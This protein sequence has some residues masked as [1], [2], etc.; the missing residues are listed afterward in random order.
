MPSSYLGQVTVRPATQNDFPAIRALI[1]AV[2]INPMGLDW[3]RFLAAVDENGRLVGCGQVKPH[4]DGSLELAS[5]AVVPE[6]RGR[7]VARAIL[8][9]LLETYPR[10]LYLTCRAHLG[11]FYEKFGFQAVEEGEMPPY[12]RRIKRLAKLVKSIGI[13]PGDLLVMRKT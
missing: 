11:P 7:G 10:P 2:R 13:I 6:Q 4:R 1:Y 5:I 3:R 9:R 8:E 12:F